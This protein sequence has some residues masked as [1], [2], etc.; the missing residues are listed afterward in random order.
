MNWPS[1]SRAKIYKPPRNFRLFQSRQAL[2]FF[3][4]HFFGK[5]I[6]APIFNI[7]SQ[8][9]SVD[10]GVNT[11]TK[12]ADERNRTDV[13]DKARKKKTELSSYRKLNTPAVA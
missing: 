1:S 11:P 5:R 13:L 10:S 7:L 6:K 2:I 12:P 8:G 4:D 3:S 9:R